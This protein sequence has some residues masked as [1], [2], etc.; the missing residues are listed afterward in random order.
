MEV[1]LIP[2]RA[3]ILQPSYRYRADKTAMES[4]RA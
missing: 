3:V 4:E 1:V 2:F